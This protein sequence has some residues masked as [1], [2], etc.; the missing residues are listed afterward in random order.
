[1]QTSALHRGHNPDI[2]RW[3]AKDPI[4]F[5]GGDTDLYG[6]CLS[7]PVNLIDPDGLIVEADPFDTSPSAG[8]WLSNPAH[9]GAILGATI[10]GLKAGA[11]TENPLAG[12]VVGGATLIGS[13]IGCHTALD[14]IFPE[15]DSSTDPT[16]E[17]SKPCK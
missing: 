6:Y 14:I 7:D 16:N 10:A 17:S 3:T 8:F 13:C 15:T 11:E 4:L 12:V 2:G 9:T 1:M 5:A